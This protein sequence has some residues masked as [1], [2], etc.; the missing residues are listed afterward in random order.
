MRVRVLGEEMP[1]ARMVLARLRD[2]STGLVEFRRNLRLAGAMLAISISRELEW[3]KIK[4]KTPLGVAEE[5][6][7][8]KPPL[9]VAILGAGVVMAEGFLEVY[10]DAPLGLV[11]AKRVEEPGR[12]SVNVFY[13]RLPSQV[14]GAAVIIDPMLATGYTIDAVA[15]DLEER[16]AEK[17][18]IA[19]V[20]AS[21]DGIMYLAE[22]HPEAVLHTLT[23]D[24]K[25][26]DRFFIVPGLGD[27]GDRS[28]GVEPG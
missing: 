17:I 5:L 11:A 12:V 14:K 24:P 15:S 4:V 18:I 26:D 16:G 19:S 10:E 22:R 1:V 7:L 23:V 25:L 3:E 2:E 21:R 6:R 20:I 9:L 8:A 27:A 28:L 13:R